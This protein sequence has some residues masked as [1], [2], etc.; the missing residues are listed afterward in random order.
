MRN[1]PACITAK[2]HKRMVA[3]TAPEAELEIALPAFRF[4]RAEDQVSGTDA[5]ATFDRPLSL[6][7]LT[8]FAPYR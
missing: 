7:C 8:A 6:F 4:L 5:W 1:F 3:D 2:D